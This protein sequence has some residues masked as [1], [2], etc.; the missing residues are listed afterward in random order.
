VPN[1]NL[2]EVRKALF[3]AGAGSIGN[4]DE[5]S[6]NIKGTGTFKPNA[7]ANPVIGEKEKLH[8]EEETQLNITFPKHIE[9][10]V[11]QA[12]FKSH[13]YE[14]VAYEIT[15]LENTNQQIGIGMLGELEQEIA[16]E[17]FLVL[18][19]EKFNLQIIRHSRLLPKKIKKIAVLGGSGAFA[20]PNAIALKADIYITADLKYH[21]FYQAE[22]KLI[23]AD[24]GHY[25]SEQFTKE[26]LHSYLTK[27]IPNFAI[28][29][30]QKSTNPIQYS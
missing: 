14:E 9:N 28:V 26:L 4:Y 29:L 24:I 16:A 13:P 27:K 15:T 1:K 23:L 25:E 20:I 30:S 2:V 7:E 12:L 3:E 19:K 18:L 5:C 6:F 8:K 10:A 22:G 21:D 11:L 17:D